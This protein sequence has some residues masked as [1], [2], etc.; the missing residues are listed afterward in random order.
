[1]SSFCWRV[2][3]MQVTAALCLKFV[4]LNADSTVT[5]ACFSITR[6]LGS[7][8][9]VRI[10]TKAC[11]FSIYP[12][13]GSSEYSLRV[14]GGPLWVCSEVK[15]CFSIHRELGRLCLTCTESI[16]QAKVG[17]WV[18]KQKPVP[19]SVEH[20][21]DLGRY[22][23]KQKPAHLLVGHRLGPTWCPSLA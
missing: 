16:W 12:Q 10:K 21:A 18:P 2:G 7:P 20:W 19:V 23:Q 4:L 3:V 5:H 15:P 11:S 17:R 6:A 9:W 22:T 8:R 14:P 13:E 1:M